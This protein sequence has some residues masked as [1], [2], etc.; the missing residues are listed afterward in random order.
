MPVS[1]KRLHIVTGKGGSGKTTVA[2]ALA[3]ALAERG[4]SV[5][6]CEVEG[7]QGIARLFEVDPL[8][9]AEVKVAAGLGPLAAVRRGGGAVFA[10]HIDPEAALREYLT[11]YFKLGPAARLLTTFGAV[12]FATSIAPG[13]RDVL[14]TGK[15]YEAAKAVR[16]GRDTRS[17][18]AVVLDAPP[19][20][21]I[22]QFLT[23]N[24]EL[25]DLAGMGPMRSQADA[26]MAALRSTRTAVHVVTLLEEMPVREAVEAID[27]FRTAGLPVGSVIV[28]QARPR[29]LTTA[30]LGLVRADRIDL[31]EVSSALTSV[32]LSPTPSLLASLARAG[33]EHAERRELEDAQRE[34]LSAVGVD[35][36]ELPVLATGI[37]RSS[38]Y[39]L[40]ETL[41]DQFGRDQSGQDQSGRDQSGQDQSGRDQLRQE[42]PGQ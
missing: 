17:Y 37:N 30:Q 14:L 18:D 19:T 39:Q 24:G 26:V 22:T 41:R 25:A 36:T 3:L 10:L 15:L 2:A 12:E 32:G 40:A 9:S 5:L 8:A 34:I 29:A 35:V 11:T 6:L 20:G 13:L 33:A 16:R 42:T 21:R 38:L 23:S 7:R 28:N 31:S 1:S 27:Q 4:K